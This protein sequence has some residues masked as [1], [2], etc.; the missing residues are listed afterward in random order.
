MSRRPS[1]AE[2]MRQAAQPDSPAPATAINAK[3]PRKALRAE[4]Q[5]GAR[6]H[7]ATRVGKKKVTGNI[8]PSKKKLLKALAVQRDTTTEALLEEAIDDLFRKYKVP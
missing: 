6:F 4:Q 1:L 2:S 8:S 3:E 5:A 7:A